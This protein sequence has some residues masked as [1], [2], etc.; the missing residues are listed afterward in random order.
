M[1]FAICQSSIDRFTAI[2]LLDLFTVQSYSLTADGSG[3]Q[4]EAWSDLTTGVKGMLEVSQF[5]PLQEPIIGGHEQEVRR[6]AITL[7]QGTVVNASMR[8]KQ[9]HKSGVA[10]TPRYF[11]ILSVM[12]GTTFDIAVDVEAEELPNL[13]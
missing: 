9:T 4:T 11:H 2:L 12:D 7:E 8:L 3:G 1:S 5:R 13:A 6:W 10:I